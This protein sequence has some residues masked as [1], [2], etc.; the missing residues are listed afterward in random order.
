MIEK[1]PT[2]TKAHYFV[3]SA[4]DDLSAMPPEVKDVFGQAIFM[5]Q[6]GEKHVD[7][8]PMQGFGGAGVLE[9]VERHDGD[10]YRAVYTVKFEGAVYTLHAFKKKS[11]KGSQ[12]PKPDMDLIKRRLKMAQDDYEERIKRQTA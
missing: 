10:T 2:A 12:T 7:A 6:K 5:A 4:R 9:V 3:G 8:K 11:K 1:L